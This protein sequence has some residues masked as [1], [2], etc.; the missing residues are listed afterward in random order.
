MR[1]RNDGRAEDC[2]LEDWS[3]AV[4]DQCESGPIHGE[5]LVAEFFQK[6]E[7]G[8]TERGALIGAIGQMLVHP[9]HESNRECVVGGPETRDHRFCAGQKEGAFEAGDSLLTEQFSRSGIASGKSY[10]FGAEGKITDFSNL[11]KT[12]LSGSRPNSREPV[13][14]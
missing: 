7:F 6:I 9:F 3:R 1:R 12:V 4:A 10:Q 8:L 14:P 13:P 5:C 11:Q 2:L